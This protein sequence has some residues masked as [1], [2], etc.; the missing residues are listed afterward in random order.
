MSKWILVHN[1]AC[2]LSFKNQSYNL[3]KN[4]YESIEEYNFKYEISS[5][6]KEFD[7]KVSTA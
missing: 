4:N 5:W 1:K 7:A 2:H 6:F 3:I